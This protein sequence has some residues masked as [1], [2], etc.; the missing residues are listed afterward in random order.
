[1]IVYNETLIVEEAIYDEWLNYMKETHIP[2]IMA[3]GY[4]NSYKILTVIDSPNEGVTTCIQYNTDSEEKFAKFYNQHLHGF[5]ASHNAL[6][7]NRFVLYS[8]LMETIAEGG[9]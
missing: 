1:M 4:F 7:E 9:A 6:Y 3:T 5:H 2:G 8:T